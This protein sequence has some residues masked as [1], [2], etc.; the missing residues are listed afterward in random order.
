MREALKVFSEVLGI[1]SCTLLG[2][3][4]FPFVDVERVA[5]RPKE[6]C[7]ELLAALA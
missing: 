5:P 1:G 4:D 7:E 3:L 2:C 6:V